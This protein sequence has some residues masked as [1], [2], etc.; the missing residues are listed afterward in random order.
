MA[1]VIRW[2]AALVCLSGVVGAQ[3]IELPVP[4]RPA[5]GF[6][7]Q[8]RL[9]EGAPESR[10]AI[11]SR[12]A[13]HF[14]KTG[15]RVEVAVVDSLIGRTVFDEA[16]RLR[17]GWLAGDAGLVLVYEADSGDWEIGWSDRSIRSEG[18]ELPAVGPSEVGP[19]QRVAIM[20]RLG[21]LPK[22]GLRSREDAERLIGTLMGALEE[23]AAGAVKPQRHLGRLLLLGVGLAAGLLLIGMLIAAGV[24]RADRQAEDRLYFPD[25]EVAE[26]LKAPRGGGVVSSRSFGSSS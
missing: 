5:D 19:Q 16:Q 21:A 4:P 11:T 10:A 6:F 22:P 7:D 24:R 17:D 15:F 3:G 26:R 18:R 23:Q 2:L 14:E 20:S 8:A 25:I 1:A 9:F 13:D 12:L